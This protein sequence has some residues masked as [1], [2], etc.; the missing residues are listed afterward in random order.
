MG[1]MVYQFL[2]KLDWFSTL[3]PRIPVPIQ[4][5]IERN[6][7]QYCRENQVS[8]H[9]LNSARA[10]TTFGATTRSGYEPEDNTHDRRGA[11]SSSSR[12]PPPPPPANYRSEHDDRDFYQAA[13]PSSSSSHQH[14]R[15]DDYSPS[16][17]A[18]GSRRGS[19]ERSRH[20]EKHKK[21][22][23]HKH[24]SRSRSRSKSQSRSGRHERGTE[25]LRERERERGGAPSHGG[26]KERDLYEDR[27]YR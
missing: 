16:P 13:I 14:R 12:A 5:Q 15:R 6:L 17:A 22:H 25:R 19:R 1:Q 23:K 11:A 9:Q 27:R 26:G 10:S 8:L 21:K 24:H 2:T 20:R 18:A 4:K 7:E 3:F